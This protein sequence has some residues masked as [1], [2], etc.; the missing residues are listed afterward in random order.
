MVNNFCILK[1]ALERFDIEHV[2]LDLF[3]IQSFEAAPVFM[4]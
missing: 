2:S 1:G 4:H 3:N